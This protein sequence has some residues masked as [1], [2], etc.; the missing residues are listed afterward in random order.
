M[1]SVFRSRFFRD[2]LALFFAGIGLLVGWPAESLIV[3]LVTERGSPGGNILR[4]ALVFFLLVVSA[5]FFIAGVINW[6]SSRRSEKN[7]GR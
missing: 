5:L 3:Q 1:S 4:I 2:L 6:T 7:M